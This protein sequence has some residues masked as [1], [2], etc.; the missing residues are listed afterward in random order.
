MVIVG[1]SGGVDSSVA[2]LVLK[3]QGVKLAGLFMKNWEEDD[4][5]GTCSAEA[6]AQSARQAAATLGIDFYT[7]NFA[8]EY[9][10]GVFEYFLS[11]LK[12]NRTPNPDVLCNREVKFKTFIEHASALGAKSI[13]TGHYARK[14]QQNGAFAL[15]KARDANKDQSYFL[16]QLN[17]AQLAASLF[18]LGEL[19][20]P[21]VRKLALEFGLANHDRKDSTGI[22]FIGERNFV[23]FLKR[24]LT[25]KPGRMQTLAGK[26]VGP[27]EG[28]Q[29]YTLGQRG[30]LGIGG[31]KDGNG[32]PWFVV[33]KDAERNVLIVNQGDCAELYAHSLQASSPHWIG[34]NPLAKQTRW[35]GFAKTR[36]RQPDQACE[37]FYVGDALE[38]RFAEPQRAVTPG[39]FVVFYQGDLC[40]GG[41]TIERSDAAFG[42]LLAHSL[43]CK[44]QAA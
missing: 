38:V 23:P 41:A 40:L 37:I 11:E 5:S 1:L 4:A 33:A 12:A 20:K 28:L 30:G 24:F 29:F 7:R 2:A 13:A 14:H 25:P 18:P 32:Q 8:T 6:D 26:D 9:W 36:Y 22:C 42:G 35:Q 16:H 10:D 3:A 27:H 17:Q 19:L 43:A 44:G 15:L 39:Q 31:Q 21:E 34:E